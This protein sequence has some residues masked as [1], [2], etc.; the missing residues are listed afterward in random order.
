MQ[1]CVG[2]LYN[3]VMYNKTFCKAVAFF[4]HKRGIIGQMSLLAESP[5]SLECE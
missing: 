2:L 3:M 1:L 5:F 4:G